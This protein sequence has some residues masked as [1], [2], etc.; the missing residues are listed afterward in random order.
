MAH[1]D[2][3][4][5]SDAID[6]AFIITGMYFECGSTR[7]PVL[8][9]SVNASIFDSKVG[10]SGC[11]I[12]VIPTQVDKRENVKG[13]VKELD[14]KKAS[15][16]FE[17]VKIDSEGSVILT[18]TGKAGLNSSVTLYKGRVVDTQINFNTAQTSFSKRFSITLGHPAATIAAHHVE[19]PFLWGVSSDR[20][21]TLDSYRKYL[22]NNKGDTAKY[23][24]Q[25]G[26]DLV[27]YVVDT[28]EG[29][30]KRIGDSGGITVSSLLNINTAPI[31]NSK[32]KAQDTTGKGNGRVVTDL[33]TTIYN[34]LVTSSL[35]NSE[36]TS[37]V[38]LLD[39]FELLVVPNMR[40]G[41]NDKYSDSPA[42]DDETVKLTLCNIEQLEPSR[43]EQ[44]NID[45]LKSQDHRIRMRNGF[46][47]LYFHDDRNLRIDKNYLIKC[48]EAVDINNMN[49]MEYFDSIDGSMFDF[50]K[51]D[52]EKADNV[53]T[54]GQ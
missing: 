12:T 9:A 37:L 39:Q 44:A 23:E 38:N 49:G 17:Q 21:R 52:L 47:H 25:R 28:L 13:G 27:K 45:A 53:D 40:F 41:K 11:T 29:S 30:S 36:W 5:N 54:M 3:I 22:T 16:T 51:K 32:L 7:F 31:I 4:I 48:V 42:C 18:N 46:K 24:T 19:S 20:T 35:S 14:I 6:E 1:I 43:E 2:Q 34:Q 33:R 26:F 50:V 15:K 10:G 8:T